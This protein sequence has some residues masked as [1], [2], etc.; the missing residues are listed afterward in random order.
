MLLTVLSNVLSIVP[1]RVSDRLLFIPRPAYLRAR[2][3]PNGI[4]PVSVRFDVPHV[5]S[6]PW[7]PAN[8]RQVSYLSKEGVTIMMNNIQYAS[9]DQ[10][11]RTMPTTD[12]K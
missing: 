2:S 4:R 12:S 1:T 6:P 10:G 11:N 9:M 7:D 5:G 8:L 3:G